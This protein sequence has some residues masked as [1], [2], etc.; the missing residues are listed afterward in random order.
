[1]DGPLMDTL[2]LVLLWVLLGVHCGAVVLLAIWLVRVA[3][4]RG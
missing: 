3:L 2:V 4:G 1:M